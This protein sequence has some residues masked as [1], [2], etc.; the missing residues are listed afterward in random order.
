MLQRHGLC[1]ERS[2]GHLSR[3]QGLSDPMVSYMPSVSLLVC[4]N[5]HHLG[6][7]MAC[8]LES[9]VLGPVYID[10]SFLQ[11]ASYSN[12]SSL[13][14]EKLS[15]TVCLDRHRIDLNAITVVSTEVHTLLL[16]GDGEPDRGIL[17]RCSSNCHA[18][19]GDIFRRCSRFPRCFFDLCLQCSREVRAG[20]METSNPEADP[21]T[22]EELEALHPDLARATAEGLEE[23][24]DAATIENRV[25]KSLR[26][27]WK[28]SRTGGIQCPDKLWGGCG[29][30]V[31]TLVSLRGR[32]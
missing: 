7:I 22:A 11:G 24:G 21:P 15:D 16:V 18:G 29:G 26:P 17:D 32:A 2:C 27:S 13:G 1:S 5:N 6:P 23:A 31:L 9:P 8:L 12:V 14:V 30:G 20:A 10:L 19:I 25:N 4:G 3:S 28:V